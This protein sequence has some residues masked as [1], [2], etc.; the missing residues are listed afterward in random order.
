MGSGG[1]ARGRAKERTRAALIEAARDEFAEK[2]LDGP[3]LDAICAR[4]GYTRG[5]FYVHFEDR[6]ALVAAVMEDGLSALLDR[7]IADARDAGDLEE[8]VHRYVHIAAVG[9]NAPL[10]EG[11][12]ETEP[13]FRTPFDQIL[14]ACQR[15]EALRARFASILRGAADR[16]AEV[17]RRAQE[18]GVARA[19]VDAAAVGPLLILI[20]LGVRIGAELELNFDVRRTR[21]AALQL[22]GPRPEPGD[23]AP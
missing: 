10:P 19:D 21:A 22:L 18:R 14:A 8:I 6:E 11:D 15:N 5:A 7:V 13:L 9:L 2:G 1:T 4:A 20:A 3:S 16:V 23:E 12:D 17:I